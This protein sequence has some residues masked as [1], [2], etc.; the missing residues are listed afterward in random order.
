V[1]LIN[2]LGY[3]VIIIIIFAQIHSK[4]GV[5]TQEKVNSAD[6][7]HRYPYCRPSIRT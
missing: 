6:K 5:I 3:T 1:P 7:A 4:T 2:L